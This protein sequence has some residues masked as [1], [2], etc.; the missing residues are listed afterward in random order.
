MKYLWLT[1]VLFLILGALNSG[2]GA[3]SET[4]I[5][6]ITVTARKKAED[7]QKVPIG[8][9][10][11]NTLGI[12]DRRM[13]S[14]SDIAESTPNFYCFDTGIIGLHTPAIRG[15]AGEST[16]SSVGLYVD[17]IPVLSGT[18][19][20]VQL[21]DIERVEVLRGPQGSLYG[22][23]TQVGAVNIISRPPE[24]I[25]SGKVS[26]E[27]GQGNAYKA[28]ANL[29]IPIIKDKMQMR[30]SGLHYERD[31]YL[32]YSESGNDVDYRNYNYGKFNLRVTPTDTFE[33]GLIGSAM[34]HD[35]GG[36]NMNITDRYAEMMGLPATDPDEVASNIEG[37]NKSESDMQVLKLSWEVSPSWHLESITSRRTYRSYYLNDWDF[38]SVDDMHKEMDSDN[39][40]Y[41][42]ELRADYSGARFNILAGV[43]GDWEKNH[44]VERD[45]ITGLVAEDHHTR[46]RSLGLFISS[47]F[48]L[49][50]R[51][52]LS[53]SIRY[54]RDKG[55]YEEPSRD[56]E[57]NETWGEISPKL[58]LS[59]SP[60]PNIMIYTSAAKG[61]LAGGF[62]DHA[63]EDHPTTFDQESLWSYEAGIKTR[64][65]NN[66]LQLN[67]A[68][69]H[70]D[71]D[72]YQVR[73]DDGPEYNYTDNAA[74]AESSGI[75][76]EAV[77][78]LNRTTT[79][80]AGFGYIHAEFK[81]YNVDG[82]DYTGMKLPYAP[83][84]S[85]S[86]G[87]IYRHPQGFFAGADLTGFGTMYLNK[88][89]DYPLDRYA[90]LNVKAGYET[91]TFDI[92]LYADNLFDKDY[93]AD[94]Y[95]GGLYRV[96]SPPLEAG[97]SLTYRF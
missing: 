28:S 20:D 65:F 15:K 34:A 43:Y 4:K 87:L 53:P 83:E 11:F 77:V 19:F 95:F 41:S 85:G 13:T 92:Y 45:D 17:G 23:N 47:D 38:S 39:R 90:I 51:I 22:K 24:D 1:A 97:I 75:E 93:S 40:S 9:T 21:V 70:M 89:N 61:Y 46:F 49:T 7:L 80:T 29:N 88:E 84:F 63:A 25:F 2:D 42:Q 60:V 32:T 58:A 3:E 76:A 68:F 31:G 64:F 79:L 10:V 26:A 73:I 5:E 62:N 71:I 18:G 12:E 59:F 67:L 66:M 27:A 56:L 14:V 86:L 69:F 91:E 78:R 50:S 37:W 54:D 82:G 35:D 81:E 16:G 74:K 36:I 48:Y 55:K 52:T 30:V 33:I 96:A 57:I 8:V 6:S 44:F 94:G 72:D